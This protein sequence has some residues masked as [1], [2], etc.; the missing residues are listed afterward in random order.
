MKLTLKDA[1]A[2]RPGDVI[3]ITGSAGKHTGVVYAN[4]EGVIKLNCKDSK[5]VEI[6]Q[7]MIFSGVNFEFAE[8]SPEP[9]A[10]YDGEWDFV[11]NHR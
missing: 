11:S 8:R 1:R 7:I 4:S 9:I 10:L 6:T 5:K 3:N 2:I